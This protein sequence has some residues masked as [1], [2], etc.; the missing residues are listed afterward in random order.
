MLS[1]GI[2]HAYVTCPHYRREAKT[3]ILDTWRREAALRKFEEEFHMTPLKRPY[4][5]SWRLFFDPETTWKLDP[6]YPDETVP[7]GLCGWCWRVY[8]ARQRRAA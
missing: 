7:F 1:A 8:Q 4:R 2:D 6:N 3:W 5:P